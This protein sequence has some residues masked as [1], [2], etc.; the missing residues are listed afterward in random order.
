MT[1]DL[2][3]PERLK[4]ALAGKG[5]QPARSDVAPLFALVATGDRD[6]A[7]LASRA[8]ARL[9][10]EAATAALARFDAA[11]PMER[12]RLTRLVGRVAQKRRDRPLAEWLAGRIADSDEKTARN[13]ALATGRLGDLVPRADVE[14]ALIARWP[15]ATPPL[16]R[17]L[18]EALGKVGA[19]DGLALLDAAQGEPDT[20]ADEQVRRVIDEA[21]LKLSRTLGRQSAESAAIRDDVAPATPVRVVAH[22]RHGLSTILADELQRHGATVVNDETVELSLRAPLSGMWAARTMLRYGFP[23]PVARIDSRREEELERAV[24]DAITSDAAWAI[25]SRFTNGV[26]RYRLEWA[27]AGHRRGL[28]FRVAAAVAARRPGLVNDPTATLWEFVVRETG[29]LSVE[30]W[31]RGLADPRF[32]YRVAY[33]PAAS[34][35]TLAAALVLVAGTRPDDVVWDPFVGTASELIERARLGPVRALIGTDADEAALG[36]ARQNLAAAGVTAELHAGDARTFRPPLPPT[37]IITNPPMGRRVL[38]R[39]STGPLYRTFLAHAAELL[40]RGGRLVWI[41]PRPEE[42]IA[43]ATPH[44]LRCTYRQRVDMA[45][46][47]AEI[48]YFV[49][50]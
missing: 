12:A 15:S 45:G 20:A 30:L 49:K 24:V 33:V 19:A 26:P 48:Q 4:E 42:T 5:Y 6:Q 1:R 8:L 22:C 43:Y 16:K 41:S 34:H 47:F 21:R 37:L 40:V 11:P 27:D 23:L 9:G 7:E 17:A 50:R 3:D 14:R 32:T 2:S 29:R 39:H 13:A 10:S 31:P 36:H 28:T 46:F 18:A 25:L 38:D 35:P 44:G